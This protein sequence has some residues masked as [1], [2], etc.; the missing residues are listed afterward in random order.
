MVQKTRA[1][2]VVEDYKTIQRI[3]RGLLER[4]GLKPDEIQ[5][6]ASVQEALGLLDTQRFDVVLCDI[7]LE[8]AGASG[9]ELLR[10]VRKTSNPKI[11]DTPF[12]MVTTDDR[13]STVQAALELGIHGYL[14]KPFREDALRKELHKVRSLKDL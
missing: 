3:V 6:A 1:V 2:L 7:E 4:I 13:R 14:L 5:V 11:R 10:A 12:I 9:L 8:E